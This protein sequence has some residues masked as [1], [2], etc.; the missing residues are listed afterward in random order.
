MVAEEEELKEIS[1]SDIDTDEVRGT[2]DEAKDV[3]LRRKTKMKGK[4]KPSRVQGK[5]Q[6]EKVRS[7]ILKGKQE[8]EEERTRVS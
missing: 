4:N 2:P 8:R 5:K 3:Q 7:N 6:S 1:D